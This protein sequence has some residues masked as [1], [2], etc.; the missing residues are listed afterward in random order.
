MGFALP[1]SKLL[2]V[3][4]SEEANRQ[5]QAL[6]KHFHWFSLAGGQAL[7]LRAVGPHRCRCVGGSGRQRVRTVDEYRSAPEGSCVLPAALVVPWGG[8]GQSLSVCPTGDGACVLLR[9]LEPLGGLETMRQLR[10]TY[11]KG[12]AVPA[13]PSKTVSSAVAPPSSV[14]PWP[15]TRASTNET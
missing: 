1:A 12:K 4:K 15:S 6:A 9:A 5:L 8:E 10:S 14:R 2:L 13:E 3:P 7:W 11:R